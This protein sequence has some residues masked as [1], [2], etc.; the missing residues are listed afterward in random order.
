L[1]PEEELLRNDS[2]DA[3]LEGTA[4]KPK[5]TIGKIKVQGIV[6][7]DSFHGYFVLT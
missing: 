2:A 6:A 3:A 1:Q 7:S 5:K 4:P